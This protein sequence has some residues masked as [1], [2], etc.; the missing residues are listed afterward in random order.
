LEVGTAT[1]QVVLALSSASSA[2]DNQKYPVDDIN[3]PTPCTPLYVKGRMLRTIEVADAIVMATCIMHGRPIPSECAVVEVTTIREGREFEDL[4][5]LDDEEGI[6]KLKDAKGNF[7]L[8][9]HKDIIIKPVPHQLF[10]HRAE[11]MMV[12][13]LLKIPYA[14]L[15]HLLHHMK[16]LQKLPLHPKIQHLHNLLS[17]ILL[18]IVLLHMVILQ[19][20]LLTLPLLFKIYQL[21]KQLSNILIHMFILWN[22]LTL[23]L[24]FKIHHL[25][26]LLSSVL[27]HMFI[28]WSLLLTL[29]LFFKIYQLNKLLNN[30]LLHM[31]IIRSLLLTLPFFFKFHQILRRRRMPL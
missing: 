22:L 15:P 31:F 16:I 21:N 27:L 17:I 25:N 30:V 20:L 8:W 28:L 9:P 4:D 12:L 6:Q 19:S 24:L 18:S 26:K 2:P 14:A 23:P 7:I 11:R 13:Q 1:P 5:Y 29:P 10:R 3:E